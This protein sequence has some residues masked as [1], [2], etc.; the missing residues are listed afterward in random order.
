MEFDLWEELMAMERRMDDLFRGVLAPHARTRFRA[1]PSGFDQPFL[2]ATDVYGSDGDLTI[3]LEL[4]GVDP[5]GDVTVAI[6]EGDLV[7]RGERRRKEEVK[8]EDFYRMEASYGAFERRIPLPEGV[9][10]KDVKAEYKDG[11]LEILVPGAGKVLEQVKPKA[12]AI[13]IKSAKAGRAD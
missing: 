8:E 3:R 2:P 10:D 9:D 11:V 7:V 6:E 12:R 5:A 13:P 4:P 1:L